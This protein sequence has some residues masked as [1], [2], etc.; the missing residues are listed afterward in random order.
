ML[1]GSFPLFASD[2]DFLILS[3]IH[4]NPLA[5]SSKAKQLDLADVQSWESVLSEPPS[6]PLSQYGDDTDWALLQSVLQRVAH[7]REKPK[8]AIVT[9]DLFAHHLREHYEQEIPGSHDFAS[10][11]QKTALFLERELKNAVPGVPVIMALGNND[12]DCGDVDYSIE[13]GGVFL[14][15]SAPRNRR[16]N[17]GGAGGSGRELEQFRELRYRPSNVAS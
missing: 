2:P 15:K 5:Q 4:F 7:L 1:V 10:F 8:F 6:Q 17:S 13:P 11:A 14:R 16:R 3:D 12:G 9:G